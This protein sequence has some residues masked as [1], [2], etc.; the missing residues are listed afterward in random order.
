[1]SY[2]YRREPLT[3]DEVKRL[4][5]ASSSWKA[6]LVTSTLLDTGLRV[7]EL[8]T[9]VPRNLDFQT[10]RLTVYGK[11]GPYGQKSKR[12][13]IPL[14]ARTASLLEHWFATNETFPVK[15]RQ[16]E[17]ICQAA[18]SR[19]RISRKV[20]PHVLRHTFAC[21]CLKKGMNIVTVQR[22][23]GHEYLSTTQIYLNLA[24]E[25]VVRDFRE[26]W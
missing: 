8:A 16:I 15:Q 3:E 5:E 12:R 1:M 19:A 25:D 17:R 10:H 23:L 2:Q 7:S 22:L 13:V 14:P 26:R 21:S 20:T 24:P 6:N 9:I 4:T 11:G 18:G